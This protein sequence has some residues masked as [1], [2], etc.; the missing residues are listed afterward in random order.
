M[1]IAGN[2]SSF[3]GWFRGIFMPTSQSSAGRDAKTIQKARL[4]LMQEAWRAYY[5]QMPNPLRV[6]AGQPNDNIKLNFGKIIVDKNVSYLFGEDVSFQIEDT[7]EGETDGKSRHE[8]EQKL[9][10]ECWAWNKQQ[11]LLHLSGL[12]GSVT[13][14]CF[15]KI[16]L[17][18]GLPY[19]RLINLDPALVEPE[20]DP[21]DFE[22]I[23]RY[24][25]SWKPMT[26][27]KVQRRQVIEPVGIL[28]ETGNVAQKW[29]I[30]DQVTMDGG[31]SWQEEARTDWPYKF[32]PIVHCQNWPVP[33]QFWGLSDLPPDILKLLHSRNFIA[34]NTS[35]IIRFHAHPRTVASGMT[36]RDKMEMGVDDIVFLPNPQAKL[37]TLEMRGD[38]SSS[39]AFLMYLDENLQSLASIPPIALGRM[40]ANGQM[41]GVALRIRYQPLVQRIQT[42]QRLYGDML[43]DLC[44][45]LL[46]IMG[47]PGLKVEVVWPDPLPV[48]LP[49]QAETGVLLDQLGV[50]K[51]RI[52]TDLGYDWE[53]EHKQKQEEQKEAQDAM[54]TSFDRGNV[55]PQGNNPAGNGNQNG[56]QE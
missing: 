47:H 16:K 36:N 41:S 13:G 25:I 45:A 31:K 2:I 34:S 49:E 42:K 43:S 4:G 3:F 21:E 53:E 1:D 5:G 29:V 12:N 6:K 8:A 55:P 39:L 46:E 24:V 33:N 14:H 44:S 40:E 9:L 28:D 50:S 30:L 52:I 32:A 37:D 18:A 15:I 7:E 20:C 11:T 10:D 38:L 19:P 26:D 17:D 56:G 54:Q 35:R 27:D 48:N 22:R 51:K 23:L